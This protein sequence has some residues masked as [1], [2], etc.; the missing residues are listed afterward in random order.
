MKIRLSDDH[1]RIR[2]ARTDRARLETDGLLSLPISVSPSDKFTVRLEGG[3]SDSDGISV[4]L[5]DSG[6]LIR[7][8]N[9]MLQSLFD[10]V[11]SEI[12]RE[13]DSDECGVSIEVDIQ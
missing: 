13:K 6:M 4:Q 1:V 5:I 11:V 3:E 8:S 7:T 2:L 10:G 9:R 12:R